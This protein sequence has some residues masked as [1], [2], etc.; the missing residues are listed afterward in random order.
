MKTWILMLSLTLLILS[1]CASDTENK[2]QNRGAGI[3]AAAGG[4]LGGIIGHQ[5]GNATAGA[6]IGAGTGA[7]V[8]GYAGHRMDQQAKELNQVA[9]T[10]RTNEGLVTKLKSDILFDTGKSDLKP[11][12]KESLKEMADIMKKYPENVLTVN[13]YTDDTGTSRFNEQLSKQRAEAVKRSLVADGLPGNAI[14]TEGLG[15]SKPVASNDTADGRQKNRR[16]EIDV[17]VDP[18]KVPAQK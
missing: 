6:I 5:T 8:G 10:K 16:V 14:A 12:A 13:G 9:E 1:G 7:A 15:P 17:K 11:Q 2:N 4:V 3:G 18:S